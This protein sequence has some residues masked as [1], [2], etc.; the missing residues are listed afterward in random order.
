THRRTHGGEWRAGRGGGGPQSDRG[1]AAVSLEV[2]SI[3]LIPMAR[4]EA[5]KEGVRLYWLGQAGF[6]IDFHDSRIVIDAYLSDSLNKKYRGTRFPHERMMPPPVP[7]DGISDVDWVASTHG[8]TD[9]MDPETLAPLF[10][11]NPEARYLVPIAELDRAL[12]RGGPEG[13]T[14][15]VD[16]GEAIALSPAVMATALPAAHEE[17]ELDDAGRHRFLGFLFRG[18]DVSI[19]HSGDT[20][21]FDGLIKRLELEKP[22]LALLPVNGRDEERRSH[23]VP[24]NMTLEEAVEF[25]STGL[26]GEVLGHYFGLFDFNTVDLESAE[27]DVSTLPE[28]LRSRVQ[29]AALGK[30]Y[31]LGGET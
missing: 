14:V 21:P 28:R 27:R 4:G 17:E 23:G 20:V 11:A 10:E 8:H 3:P 6:L 19:Y 9:H 25:L 13:R 30:E 24:G 2:N 22:H 16:A 12:A 15:G 7:P 26:V 18:E 1:V 31:W 29:L 5:A